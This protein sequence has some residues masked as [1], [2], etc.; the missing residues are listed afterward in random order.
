MTGYIKDLHKTIFSGPTCCRKTHLILDLIEKEFNKHFYYIIITCLTLRWK[1]TY[2][3]RDLIKN[4]DKVCLIEPKDKL[5][6]WTEKLSQ[7][8]ARSEILFVIDDIIAAKSLD[9][10]RQSLLKL[11]ISGRHRDHYLWLLIQSYSAIPNNLR[12]QAKAI[13]VSYPKE[14]K[15]LKLIHNE[16]NM[17]TDDELVIVRGFLRTSK[18]A[19][20]YIWNEHPRRLKVLN[21][22]WD[23][24]FKWINRI[25]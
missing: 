21:Q 1:K 20:Q 24:H 4:D 2:H 11:A 7:L 9:K 5:Y 16:N 23:D 13:F 17:L 12:R 14:R 19:W 10:K 25:T 15:D 3:S 8:L 22:I 18:H 6:Y